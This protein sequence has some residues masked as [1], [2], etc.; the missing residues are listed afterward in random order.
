MSINQ[1]NLANELNSLAS[2]LNEVFKHIDGSLDITIRKDLL[3][4]AKLLAHAQKDLQRNQPMPANLH[5]DLNFLYVRLQDIMRTHDQNRR[6]QKSRFIT[7]PEKLE[8]IFDNLLKGRHESK[9]HAL[10]IINIRRA[11]ILVTPPSLHSIKIKGFSKGN[12]FLLNT[13]HLQ[14]SI[15][16]MQK[17]QIIQEINK[18]FYTPIV[19]DLTFI[20]HGYK[21]EW[22]KFNPLSKS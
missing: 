12:L 9:Y 19:K 15:T 2:L 17:Q 6:A 3:K 22:L 5:S 1:I 16:L 10:Q 4:F 8:T 7:K 21:R 13:N 18:H 14:I 11:W 20:T